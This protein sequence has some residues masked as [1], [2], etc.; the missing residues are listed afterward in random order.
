[1]QGDEHAHPTTGN[2]TFKVALEEQNQTYSIDLCP[3]QLKQVGAAFL[4]SCG[5]AHV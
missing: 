3:S 2:Y 5:S 1:M 4:P